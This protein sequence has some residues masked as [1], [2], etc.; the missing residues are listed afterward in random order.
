[1]SPIPSSLLR[2]EFNARV[3]LLDV[4]SATSAS[5][6]LA[7]TNESAQATAYAITKR[8]SRPLYEAHY[9]WMDAKFACRKAA[10]RSKDL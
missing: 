2:K 1:M 4:I 6:A 7:T 3:H 10:F 8:L 5:E 9:R